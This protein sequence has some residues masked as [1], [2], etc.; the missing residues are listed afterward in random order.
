MKNKIFEKIKKNFSFNNKNI[1]VAVSGGI[2]SMV[3]INLLLNK[4]VNFSNIEVLHCNFHLRGIESYSDELFIRKFCKEKKIICRI[5]RFNTLNIAKK[6]K[7]SIQ[8]MARK[9]RYDWFNK[10]LKKKIYDYIA[11]GHHLDDSIE[12]F[13][14]NIIRG[15]GGNGLKGIPVINEK[16]IRPIYFLKKKEIID[17]ANSSKIKWKND[18]SN[19]N[20]KYL[21]NKIRLFLFPL[22]SSS[23][24]DFFYS[25]IKKTMSYVYDENIFI[26]NNI[27]KICK[28]ITIEKK[29]KPFFWKID[30]QKI[31]KFKPLSF[32][33]FKLFC[34]YGFNDIKNL[35]NMIF[36]K[37]GKQMM[38]KKYRIIKDRSFWI[39]TTHK[40]YLKNKNKL[41]LIH[42]I[43]KKVDLPSIT[44]RF[45]I[46]EYKKLFFRKIKNLESLFLLDLKKIKFPLSI[47]TWRKGDFFFPI[48]GIGK[49][50]LSKYYK[51]NKFSILEKENIWLLINGDGRIIL[52]TKNCLDDRFKITKKTNKILM[53]ICNYKN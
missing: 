50:K 21:R 48:N 2:D 6:N 24:S 41:F 18:S 51:D 35:N 25:G 1:G 49:K 14:I 33:L 31:K 46:K 7:I 30:I 42:S 27:K 3:L 9:L 43:I 22:L 47:R 32:H 16:I 4:S 29:V 39:I 5:K 15:T 36:A 44:F 38:S 28:E 45:Y 19:S 10:L 34:S 13:F 23:F 37:S 20:I 40:N 26:E 53:V 8:M 12:T 52:I 11:L 17:Y